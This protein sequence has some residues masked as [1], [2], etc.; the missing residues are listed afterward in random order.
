VVVV[1]VRGRVDGRT[2]VTGVVPRSG[3]NRPYNPAFM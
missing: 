3:L 1:D 2:V